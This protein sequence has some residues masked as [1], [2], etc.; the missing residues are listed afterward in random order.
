MQYMY[1]LCIIGWKSLT[2]LC[3]NTESVSDDK[4][5][6][7]LHAHNCISN[8]AIL[9]N[10]CFIAKW[11]VRMFTSEENGIIN[12][13][14]HSSSVTGSNR[15]MRFQ[16]CDKRWAGA[17][18]GVKCCCSFMWKPSSNSHSVFELAKYFGSLATFWFS[19]FVMIFSTTRHVHAIPTYRVYHM[20]KFSVQ[21]DINFQCWKCEHVQALKLCA[22]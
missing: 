12:E 22:R 19:T 16:T 3:S 14:S 5:S 21:T 10:N 4:D 2:R 1:A 17:L 7:H 6:P 11:F 18:L 15:F 13:L 20:E 9:N 8:S